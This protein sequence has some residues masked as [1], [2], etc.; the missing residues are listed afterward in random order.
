MCRQQS[1]TDSDSTQLTQQA[2]SLLSAS[3]VAKTTTPAK[4]PTTNC[5]PVTDTDPSEYRLGQSRAATA[6]PR[7]RRLMVNSL[8]DKEVTSPNGEKLKSG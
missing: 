4:L 2:F 3:F 8:A 5:T 6:G 7:T 1:L